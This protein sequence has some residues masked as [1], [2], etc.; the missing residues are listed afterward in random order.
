MLFSLFHVLFL[1]CFFCCSIDVVVCSLFV[2]LYAFAVVAVDVVALVT[3]CLHFFF[4]IANCFLALLF[5]SSMLLL[6]FHFCC[7]VS[8]KLLLLSDLYCSWNI[9]VVLFCKT[10]GSA[11]IKREREKLRKLKSTEIAVVALL[12][13][14]FLSLL[15]SFSVGKKK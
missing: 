15:I 10:L 7:F 8:F 12:V 6:C 2:C 13:F 1:F 4:L 14:F 3:F 11:R 9:F 5:L